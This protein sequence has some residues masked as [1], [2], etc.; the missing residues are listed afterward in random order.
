MTE[1]AIYQE[2]TIIKSYSD[3]ESVAKAM[4]ASGFFNDATK[5]SQAI[6]KIMAGAEIGIGP[7]GSMNG[8]HIIQGKPAFGANVMASKVKSS[9]RYNYRV[10]E[11]S[12][13]NCT[14]E[15]M[16]YFNGAWQN[17][18][19]SSFSTADA[20]KAGTKNLDKFP[21]NMLFARAMSNGVR[22]YCPDVMNG[23][24]VYTPE[25][26]GAEVD[27][28][29]NVIDGIVTPSEV[30]PVVDQTPQAA[31]P[32][33]KEQQMTK[34]ELS[35]AVQDTRPTRDQIL[36]YLSPL[37]YPAYVQDTRSTRE[38]IQAE[39]PELTLEEACKAT[40]SNGKPYMNNTARVVEKIVS[41]LW[42]QL[43]ENHL[44]ADER[45][46]ALTKLASAIVI[47]KAKQDGSLS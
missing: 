4:V 32:E 28:D 27:E 2:G 42:K 35:A 29:G 11:L 21:R 1:L 20:K 16:E 3:V 40:D 41:A 19:V 9:G 46:E 30:E 31:E 47:L 39:L 12:D 8:I 23:S 26:L 15:F 43:L 34:Q 44:E 33:R 24:V 25:E 38:Q 5:V 17:S 13:T 10:T 14:I 36:H 37:D 6:V 22:W 45:A 18:G 7:F